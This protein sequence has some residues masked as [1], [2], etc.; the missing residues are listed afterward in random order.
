M[1]ESGRISCFFLR[2]YIYLEALNLC[3]PALALIVAVEQIVKDADE[4]K[5]TFV[6]LQW[7]LCG[8][9]S[10]FMDNWPHFKTEPAF[11]L[12]VWK[13]NPPSACDKQSST[14]I[15]VPITPLRVYLVLVLHK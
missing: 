8:K 14:N 2:L 9:P 6:L 4:V 1:A 10:V 15:Q 11:L 5:N 12:H 3:A 7:D 13:L